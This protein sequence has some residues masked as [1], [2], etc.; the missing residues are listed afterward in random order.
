MSGIPS[1][2]AATANPLMKVS[3]NPACSMSRAESASKQQGITRSPGASRRAR[4]R[5]EGEELMLLR[6]VTS[7]SLPNRARR[8]HA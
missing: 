6:N 4:S 7:A 3:S 5:V 8:T 1:R 2:L